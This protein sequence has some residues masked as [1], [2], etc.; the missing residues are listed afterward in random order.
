MSV[1]YGREV[2][3]IGNSKMKMQISIRE[4]TLSA[5]DFDNMIRDVKVIQV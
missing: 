5:V 2:I 3:C 1:F 4:L